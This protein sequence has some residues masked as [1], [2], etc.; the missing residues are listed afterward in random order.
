[1]TERD[2][3]LAQIDDAINRDAV[4]E[5]QALLKSGVDANARDVAG[6]PLLISAAWIGSPRMV[7]LLL[8]FGADPQLRGTDGQT[9]LERLMGNTEYWDAGHDEV[10]SVLQAY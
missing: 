10:K 2:W 5:V 3:R 7:R 8:E 6:D 9:A 1:M 4:E